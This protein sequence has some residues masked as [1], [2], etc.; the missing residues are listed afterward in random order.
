M[1][2]TPVLI[3]VPVLLS[4]LSTLGC[5]GGGTRQLQ[6]IAASATGM[7][8]IQLTATGTFTASPKNVAPLA[9]SWWVRDGV[10][11]DPPYTYTLTTQPYSVACQ[12]GASV[13]AIAPANPKAPSSGTIP[14]QV[15]QDLIQ[16]Q[17]A[18]SDGGFVV[19]APQTI[20]C[21]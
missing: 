17:S 12:T 13:V 1:E 11:L 7:T 19:S 16:S 10:V 14:T 18:T 20:F 3:A 6:S 15:F 21:P 4:L 8:Q 2:K 9:V 5:G